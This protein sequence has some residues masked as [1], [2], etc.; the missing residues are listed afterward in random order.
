MDSGDVCK[1]Y[2]CQVELIHDDS[3]KD[4]DRRFSAIVSWVFSSLPSKV[5]KKRGPQAA[6]R[7]RRHDVFSF[8]SASASARRGSGS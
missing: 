8:R 5:E 1:C 3:A 7:E 6:T 4:V 2:N